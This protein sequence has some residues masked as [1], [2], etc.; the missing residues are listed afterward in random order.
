M[1]G[2]GLTPRWEESHGVGLAH[3][4]FAVRETSS[5]II[6]SEVQFCPPAVSHYYYYHYHFVPQV[7]SDLIQWHQP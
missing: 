7:L 1:Q 3:I 6:I 2:C 4:G 5:Y